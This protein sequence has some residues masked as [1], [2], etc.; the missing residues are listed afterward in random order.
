[1]N[2]RSKIKL[3]LK[4][5]AID[6]RVREILEE[7]KEKLEKLMEEKDAEIDEFMESHAELKFKKNQEIKKRYQI[8]IK[9]AEKQN[10]LEELKSL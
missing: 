7:C 8:K 3:E 10:N 6:P 4:Q 9:L 5:Q 1:M 2:F